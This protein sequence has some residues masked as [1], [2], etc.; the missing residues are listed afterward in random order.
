MNQVLVQ[1]KEES[2]SKKNILPEYVHIH[3]AIAYRAETANHSITKRLF[4]IIFSFILFLFIFSWLFPLIALLIKITSRGPVFFRQERVAVNGGKIFCYKFRTMVVESRD[5]NQ[6]G[7][8]CQA[9]KN[10]PRVTRFGVFLRKTSMDELPQFWNVLKGEM[11]VVGPRPHPVA[12]SI[13]SEAVIKEYN[14]RH[15]IKPGITGWAQ[16]NGFRG[17]TQ[18]VYLMQ[19]RVNHD[20][21]Y[22][23]NWDFSLDIKIVFL[24]IRHIVIENEN[25]Y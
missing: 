21:W 20:I 3:Q 15:L 12:L 22:I 7:K 24:T 18:E 1:V 4:D 2:F 23:N 14:L 6:K 17:G 10:D 16:I 19:E 13:E 9:I 25:V 11:S 5:I 8:F